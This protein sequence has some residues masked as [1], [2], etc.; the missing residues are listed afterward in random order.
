MDN[1]A[2]RPIVEGLE[3]FDYEHN[4]ENSIAT[5]QRKDQT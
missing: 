1:I 4:N 5:E 3:P 2:N